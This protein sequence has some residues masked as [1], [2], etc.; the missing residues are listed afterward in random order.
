MSILKK[1]AGSLTILSISLMMFSC[2]ADPKQAEN[3]EPGK[4]DVTSHMVKHS[5]PDPSKPALYNEIMALHDEIMPQMNDIVGL[6]QQLRLRIDSIET[7]GIGEQYKSHFK[8]A[9]VELRRADDGMTD[10]MSNFKPG[11][12]TITSELN[13]NSYLVSEKLKIESV[14]KKMQESIKLA[15]LTLANTPLK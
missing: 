11:Y 5:E 7:L 6:S 4:I 8:H 14:K 1:T 2:K 10:W 9:M 3:A 15:Q 13:R 12:D